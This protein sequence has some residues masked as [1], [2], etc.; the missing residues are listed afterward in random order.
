MCKYPHQI[1]FFKNPISLFSPQDSYPNRSR[2]RST[3]DKKYRII[4]CTGYLKSWSS[5]STSGLSNETTDDEIQP[6][7]NAET[8]LTKNLELQ[9]A[10]D[11][12]VAVGRLQSSIDRPLDD[13][14]S[15]GLD[16]VPGSD[17]NWLT[18][19]FWFKTCFFKFGVIHRPCSQPLRGG[20]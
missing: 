16:I 4:Q 10:M 6:G 12:L 20:G 19:P 18:K 7:C 5:S 3:V 8:D 2:K 15:R 17:G 13:A 11:C 1:F 9:G 14:I